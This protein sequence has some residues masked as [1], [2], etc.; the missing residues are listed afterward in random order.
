[1]SFISLTADRS[2]LRGALPMAAI[3]DPT[4]GWNWI[5]KAP[6]ARSQVAFCEEGPASFRQ[7]TLF[8]ISIISRDALPQLF[9]TYLLHVHIQRL[10]SWK[11]K[12]SRSLQPCSSLIGRRNGFS[13][14]VPSRSCP[15][16]PEALPRFNKPHSIVGGG[17]EFPPPAPFVVLMP[18]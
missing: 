5:E 18:L 8:P 6:W 14:G 3:A 13:V 1:M 7:V 9:K 4:P 16:T 12:P 17:P 11:N 10:T 15:G 2:R